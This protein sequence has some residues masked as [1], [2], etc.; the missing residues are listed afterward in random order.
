MLILASNHGR[1]GKKDVPEASLKTQE[2]IS[3]SFKIG[4]KFYH[5][6]GVMEDDYDEAISSDPERAIYVFSLW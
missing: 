3:G 2:L 5:Q 4:G 6:H 1:S